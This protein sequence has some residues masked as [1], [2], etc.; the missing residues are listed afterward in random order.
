MKA[1]HRPLPPHTSLLRSLAAAALLAAFGATTAVADIVYV[2]AMQQNTTVTTAV[3][4]DGSYTETGITLGN[5]GVKGS[6]PGRPATPTA[7]RAYLASA[8]FTSTSG[9]VDVKPT[10][11]ESSAD[12]SVIYQIDYNWSGSAGNASQDVVFSMT[13]AG[14]TLSTNSTPLFQRSYGV[15]TAWQFMGYLTNTTTTPTISFRY[16]SGTV[17][18]ASSSRVLFD[19]WRFTKLSACNFVAPVNADGPLATNL[20]TVN[21]TGV[22]PIASQVNVYQI[23]G[24]TTNS[25]GS[26]TVTNPPATVSVI[27]SNMVKG[28]QVTATQVI[29]GQ[30]GCLPVAGTVAGGGA[31]PRIR[32]AASIRQNA[33]LTGPI[34]VNGGASSANIYWIHATGAA[35]AGGLVLQ[36]S[37]NWQTVVFYPSDSK[38]G[39][40]GS[41]ALPETNRYGCF[42]GLAFA[43]D[44][45]TDT[46]PYDL[47]I[48]NFRNGGVVIQDC[49]SVTNGSQALFWQPSVSG[50]TL[51][52][53][54]SNP[55]IAYV[56]NTY[57]ATGSKA[58]HVNWQFKDLASTRWLRLNAGVTAAP[59]W[60]PNAEVDLT[61]PIAFDILLLPANQ[62]N[63]HSMGSMGLVTNINVY[64]GGTA[65]FTEKM[66]PPAGATPNYTYVW[67]KNGTA[68]NGAT[69]ST[70]ALNSVTATDAGTY[71]VSVSDGAATNTVSATL[72]VN[73][74]ALA[75]VAITNISGT[76]LR[77]SGG[78]ASQFVLLNSTSV[79]APLSTWTR[80]A[81]NTTTPGSFPIPALGSQAQTYYRIKSE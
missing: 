55:N 46:G 64:S 37:T 20:T 27:V 16:A 29:N 40:N 11:G 33:S 26:A 61:Q 38:Y 60:T 62:T 28:A 54:L 32:V 8:L 43:L 59:G 56:T 42:E 39:W 49:E 58:Q 69:T 76:T 65:T 9:G 10:L 24:N 57:A 34:G 19:C 68:L 5:T 15:S 2:T 23:V 53:I 22:A 4:N 50:S 14:G 31:N 74:Q 63:A 36:P 67:K 30:E 81:T 3:Q 6:A 12:G 75:G 35:V 52:N 1:P 51:D 21:V 18:A 66:T 25:L 79:G 78:N 77:Y 7:S 80:V 73:G 71:S 17:S 13:C 45:L 72:T 70:L 47:Y 48:D 41:V 44:D